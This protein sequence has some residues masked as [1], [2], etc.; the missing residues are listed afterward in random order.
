VEVSRLKLSADYFPHWTGWDPK[1]QRL[2]VTP[3]SSGRDHRLYLVTLNQT[4]GA[5]ALDTAF[6]DQDG[7]PGFN[8]ADRTW[9]MIGPGPGQKTTW[10][11]SGL[12][13]GAVF[14]R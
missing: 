14:S 4:T 12:P 11:G 5:L 9:S 6:R 2:V 10:K 3:G 8:F 1:M 13:H 7:K